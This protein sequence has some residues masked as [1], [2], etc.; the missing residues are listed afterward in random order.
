MPIK[1]LIFFVKI[2]NEDTSNTEVLSTYFLPKISQGFDNK[3]N[4]SNNNA[5][6]YHRHIGDDL[7]T[8]ISDQIAFLVNLDWNHWE[9][10][11]I[12]FRT[13]VI[14]YGDSLGYAMSASMHNVLTWW[15]QLHSSANFTIKKL[16]II[17]QDNSFS[18]GLLGL[19][20]TGSVPHWC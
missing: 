8:G 7:A 18:C 10:I 1:F 13:Q 9:L 16:P 19:E 2:F 14:L 5:F 6:H 4:Y 12:D 20:L 11:I 3:D 17:I 15:T